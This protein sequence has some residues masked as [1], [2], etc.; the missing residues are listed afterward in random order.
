MPR[1]FLFMT[2][3]VLAGLGAALGS[4]LG[5]TIG[6]TGLRVGGIMGGLVG[7]AAAA[8]LGV[9]FRWI[10]HR[11]YW[12]TAIGAMLGF[13]GAALIALNTLS[14]P[15]GPVLSTLLVGAGALIGAR[16]R[17]ASSDRLMGRH[18]DDS[19]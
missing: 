3:C 17:V 14:S 15:I 4:V 7:S 11:Q 13:L 18:T 12:A 5:H 2:S 8:A 19:F 10:A 6:P 1:V 9:S 16:L